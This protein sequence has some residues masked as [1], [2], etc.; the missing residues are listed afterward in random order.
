MLDSRGDVCV[1]V[2]LPD[3]PLRTVIRDRVLRQHDIDPVI[4][5]CLLYFS[6]PY[7]Y[8]SVHILMYSQ[9][10]P[11]WYSLVQKDCWISTTDWITG[12]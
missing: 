9:F 12:N 7:I 8:L 10:T 6:F 1:C 4:A 11:V 3:I 5:F 2:L